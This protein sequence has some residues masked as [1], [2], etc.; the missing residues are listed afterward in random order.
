MTKRDT[1]N[2]YLDDDGKKVYIGITNDIERRRKEHRNKGKKFDKIV[3]VGP[4]VSRETAEKREEEALK[5]YKKN[6][7][8]KLPMYNKNDTGK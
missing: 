5:T 1:H 6:H 2:Y 7:K 8:G 3:P 4:A